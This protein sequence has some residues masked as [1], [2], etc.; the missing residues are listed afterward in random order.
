VRAV[1]QLGLVRDLY[2]RKA[3]AL[4]LMES[5]VQY[6][7]KNVGICHLLSFMPTL[8][9]SKKHACPVGPPAR[10]LLH[11]PCAPAT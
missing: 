6:I 4:E 11:L 2:G 3:D 1:Y 5:L 7:E 9:V 8:Q 10:R